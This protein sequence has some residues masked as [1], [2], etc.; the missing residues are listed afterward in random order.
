MATSV[1]DSSLVVSGCI[2]VEPVSTGASVGGT[3]NAS[4]SD[5]SG[6][7][8][9]TGVTSSGIGSSL[10]DSSLDEL[11]EGVVTPSGTNISVGGGVATADGSEDTSTGLAVLIGIS[12]EV[13]SGTASLGAYSSE[14]LPVG[15]GT[16]LLD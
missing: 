9:V 7:V 8:T 13:V 3:G 6:V 15:S 12:L 11:E 2:S 14:K 10:E 5:D 1:I 4:P 16:S